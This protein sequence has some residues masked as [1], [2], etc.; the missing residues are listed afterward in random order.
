MPTK[1]EAD[2]L[3]DTIIQPPRA[4]LTEADRILDGLLEPQD[5]PSPQIPERQAATAQVEADR[6]LDETLL[7]SGAQIERPAF[8]PPETGDPAQYLREFSGGLI[9]LAPD[10][11][12]QHT[13]IERELQYKA[14]FAQSFP[15]AFNLL[16]QDEQATGNKYLPKLFRTLVRINHTPPSPKEQLTSIDDAWSDWFSAQRE[17]RFDNQKAPPI[18]NLD[19]AAVQHVFG[20][21]IHP[22]P[23]ASFVNRLSGVVPGFSD[24]RKLDTNI[25][26]ISVLS[27]D[28]PYGDEFDIFRLAGGNDFLNHVRKHQP[29]YVAR[30]RYERLG[31]GISQSPLSCAT[32]TRTTPKTPSPATLPLSSTSTPS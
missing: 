4:D 16:R 7:Q 9:D 27:H 31:G 8:D 23:S 20:K 12:S 5:A 17:G 26:T 10:S 2:K 13:Q 1:N 11:I 21:L 28:S 24:L 25:N 14:E 19:P 30:S 15:N 18:D 6:Q 29:Y 32:R 3:L 22:P